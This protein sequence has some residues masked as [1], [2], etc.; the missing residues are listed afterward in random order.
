MTE[1]QSDVPGRASLSH[2]E[3]QVIHQALAAAWRICG[4]G[5][6]QELWR[7]ASAELRALTG[8]AVI[9]LDADRAGK[10][11]PLNQRSGHGDRT[12]PLAVLSSIAERLAESWRAQREP[13]LLSLE[14]GRV[15]AVSCTDTQSLRGGLALLTTGEAPFTGRDQ[16]VLALIGLAAGHALGA[17][18]IQA[19]SVPLE[20]HEAALSGR[21]AELSRTL[22][23]GP[24]QDLATATLA[25]EHLL[26]IAAGQ[27]LADDANIAL[28][29]V[30]FAGE[31]LRQFIAQLRGQPAE[32]E[33]A[34]E[35]RSHLAP[36]PQPAAFFP[37]L[38]QEEA[39]LAIIREALRNARAHARAETVTIA[40]TR[41]QGALSV[42]IADDGQ[43][44]TGAAPS[45]HFGLTEMRELA[46][47]IGGEITISSTPGKGTAIRLT[48]PEPVT[49]PIKCHVDAHDAGDATA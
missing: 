35:E 13:T 28:A 48:A 19:K 22:H 4:V 31:N 17:L 29:Y 2:L 41:D 21:Q 3:G 49:D 10:L 38:G 32:P 15:L 1:P 23:S 44:F 18:A 45:G 34:P 8:A 36:T 5:T 20:R 16:A 25:L 33:P 7:E 42:Q 6:R 47:A 24:A 27:Q 40:V 46:D 37:D 43:G 14:G 12:V 9:C 39:I 30:A 26:S 11:I